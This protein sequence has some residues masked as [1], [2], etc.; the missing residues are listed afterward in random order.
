MTLREDGHGHPSTTRRP[1]L[2][3]VHFGY[4]VRW[5]R[6]SEPVLLEELT[7][8]LDLLR[9]VLT[10][11]TVDRLADE[12]GVAGVARVLLDQIDE[13]STKVRT[14]RPV[15]DGEWLVETTEREGVAHADLGTSDGA[16]PE[17]PELLGRVHRRRGPL[18]ILVL[19]HRGPDAGV[20]AAEELVGEVV[21]LHEGQMLD[22][23]PQGQ[24]RGSHGVPH[25]VRVEAPVFQANVRRLRCSAPSNASTSFGA[26]AKGRGLNSSDTILTIPHEAVVTGRRADLVRNAPASSAQFGPVRA[27]RAFRAT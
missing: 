4:A 9:G 1:S 13:D 2:A 24:G 26:A 21:I 19:A 10:D 12:V 5:G 7:G 25:R 27:F 3:S 22:E 23:S 20:V 8:D 11:E 17:I 14:L 6:S 15:R 16:Q 18:P